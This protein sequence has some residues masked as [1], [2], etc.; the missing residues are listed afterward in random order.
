MA[1]RYANKPP[2]RG[3]RKAWRRYVDDPERAAF[4][5]A[6]FAGYLELLGATRKR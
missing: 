2:S 1:E 3:A 4:W 5:D 6:Q